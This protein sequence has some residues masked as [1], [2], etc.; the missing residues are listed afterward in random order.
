M[1]KHV[2]ES[3]QILPLEAG[4]MNKS[5]V[6]TVW[7]SSM[8]QSK[9][10]TLKRKTKAAVQRVEF[11]QKCKYLYVLIVI[12]FHLILKNFEAHDAPNL[13]KLKNAALAHVVPIRGRDTVR[14]METNS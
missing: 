2:K 8:Y 5:L 6:Q 7:G 14:K 11:L 3:S 9:H 12:Q 13:Q 10:F 4:F 1:K